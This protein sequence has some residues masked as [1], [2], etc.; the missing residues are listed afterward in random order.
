MAIPLISPIL[1]CL[2]HFKCQ[3]YW[4]NAHG[5]FYIIFWGVSAC[6]TIIITFC[7]WFLGL[8]RCLC[9][10]DDLQ[11]SVVWKSGTQ[12]ICS[13]IWMLNKRFSA[14][15]MGNLSYLANIGRLKGGFRQWKRRLT[16]TMYRS[17]SCDW[18]SNVINSWSCSCSSNLSHNFDKMYQNVTFKVIRSIFRVCGSSD[19]LHV[20]R[21]ISLTYFWFTESCSFFRN[22][23]DYKKENN[24]QDFRSSIFSRLVAWLS[25]YVFFLV[26]K[27]VHFWLSM[28]VLVRKK[29]NLYIWWFKRQTYDNTL[30]EFGYPSL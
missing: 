5:V 3:F 6:L 2:S 28:P 9:G 25:I 22:G 20:L 4:L 18:G 26:S 1:D 13:M 8:P 16:G 23:K 10:R 11:D 12:G 30:P 19:S 21:E 27:W 7:W 15:N 17:G 24:E 14:G 29:R